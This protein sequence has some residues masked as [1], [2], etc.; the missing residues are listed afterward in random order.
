MDSIR[1][2][3]A[4]LNDVHSLQAIGRATFAETFSAANTA[5]NMA[6]YLRDG[7]SLDKLSAELQ[8]PGSRFFLAELDGQVIGYLK[9]NLGTSQ[10]EIK[11]QRSMEIERIYVLGNYHGGGVGQLLYDKALAIAKE[12]GASYVWLGVWE[13][14]PRAIAFYRRNGFVEFDKHVFKLGNDEQTDIM[15]RLELKA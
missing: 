13:R 11:D 6:A 3:A 9:V 15:M 2:R 7:F 10:T 14:N 4:G 8:D 1:I 12:L 5:E